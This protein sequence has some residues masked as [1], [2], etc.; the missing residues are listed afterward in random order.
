LSQENPVL[1]QVQQ[2]LADQKAEVLD[3]QD[4]R[5]YE[6]KVESKS[7]VIPR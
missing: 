2:D 5:N 4:Q 7:Q 3:S 6:T 1:A